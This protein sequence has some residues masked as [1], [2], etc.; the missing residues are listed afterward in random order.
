MGLQ[1][2]QQVRHLLSGITSAMQARFEQLTQD[3]TDERFD[4]LLQ[5]TGEL[6]ATIDMPLMEM[7]RG[8]ADGLGLGFEELL[9]YDLVTY[10]RDDLVVRRI[11]GSEGCTTWAATGS[12]TADGNP[13]LIKN[14]DYLPDHLPLQVV[15]DAAPDGGYHYLYV[16]SAGSP[17]V[18]SA[19]M[20]ETGLAVADTHVFSSDLGP[21]LPDFALMM[22]IL[23]Q[24]GTVSSAVDYLRGVPRL[25][26]NNLILADVEGHLAVFES[27]NTH[28]G[29]LETWDG[30]LVNTNHFATSKMQDRFVKVDP[31]ESRG[32][33]YRRYDM[34]CQEL[35]A[36]AGRVDLAFAQ[37]LMA[38][39]DGRL[40]SICCHP[41]ANSNV[42]TISAT[43]F[44]PSLRTMFFCHGLPC[45]GAYDG[46]ALLDDGTGHSR[47][48]VCEAAQ[49]GMQ[50][51][52]LG[53][54]RKWRTYA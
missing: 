36:H 31:P 29:L 6:M 2:G 33:T 8:Q 40:S 16:S 3:G 13:M 48:A 12:V 32:R 22:R 11:L 28:Y 15:C 9:R 53:Q 5:E 24:H 26:R 23:E 43:V 27:G 44:L 34:V 49:S 18:F 14:R 47:S 20:N 38:F 52:N 42:T 30:A 39:H 46:Y 25:G 4:R 17:G 51:M 37:R 1:H 50:P 45:Q 19:G 21:G 10:L 41:Q 35:N 54:V 7:I